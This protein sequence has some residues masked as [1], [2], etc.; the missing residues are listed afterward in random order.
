MKRFEFNL[1]TLQRSKIDDY[2]AFPEQL[3]L[4]PYTIEHLSGLAPDGKQDMFELVG[5]LVHAGTAES[6]HYYSY[7]RERPLNQDMTPKWVEFNDDQVGVWNPTMME[8]S[9]FGG[10]ERRAI[11]EENSMAF[12][13]SYSAYMLFYQ[14]V[15]P[16]SCEAEAAPALELGQCLYTEKGKVLKECIRSQNVLLLRRHC[17]FDPNHAKFVQACIFQ[18]LRAEAEPDGQPREEYWRSKAL[19]LTVDTA[20]SYLDQI[21]SRKKD[22]AFALQFC[23][24]LVEMARQGCAGYVLNYFQ[25]RPAVLRSLLL[26]NPERYIRA[27]TGQLFVTCLEKLSTSFPQLYYAQPSAAALASDDEDAYMA[28][29]VM[30]DES[31]LSRAVKLL[32]QLWKYFQHHIKAW[33]EYFATV[34][35]V[36]QLGR[37]ECAAIL[38]AGY[39]ERCLTIVTADR[40]MELEPNYVKMLQNVYRRFSGQPP[41]YMA[42]LA[43]IGFLMS[44]LEP[45]ISHDTIVEAADDRLTHSGEYFPWTATE[46]ARLLTHPEE[47]DSSL[48][49]ARLLEI[50]QAPEDTR[51]IL[52]RIMRAG[53]IPTTKLLGLLEQT[54]RGD[55]TTEPLDSFIRA[56][57]IVVDSCS[58]VQHA[59]GLVLHI[60]K[61]AACFQGGEGEAFLML[62]RRALDNQRTSEEERAEMRLTTLRT[63]P[64]W[65]SYLLQYPDS[66]VRDGTERLVDNALRL[67]VET[68]FVSVEAA[69][70]SSEL[71]LGIGMSCLHFLQ[72]VH[73][74]RRA[75]IE[76]EL[77]AVLVRVLSNCS[78]VVSESETLSEEAKESFREERQGAYIVGEVRDAQLTDDVEVLESMAALVVDGTEED[79]T[80]K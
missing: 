7:V 61:Q 50:N 20:L 55:A 28:G 1:Q 70:L 6:G 45:E 14:R 21:F 48:F 32:D 71:G 16:P 54:I 36:A 3:N 46:V 43:L 13:K 30:E 80:G 75:S 42:V 64:G 4:Q 76:R 35:R 40:S 52:E 69:A 67:P 44:R 33:D 26:R 5:V 62:I 10:P 53:E 23:S 31:I 18:S 49:M 39:L 24:A 47:E 72:E 66:Q 59:Q 77:A 68:G 37:E 9:T 19:Q 78:L 15:V 65:A 74:K 2:F 63:I 56:A 27:C 58:D 60:C 34:R 41:S 38:A 8:A 12:D 29:D 25:N 79:G 22:S 17:L 51:R 11:Y 73:M 57:S